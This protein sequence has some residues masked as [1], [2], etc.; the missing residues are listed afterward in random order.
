MKKKIVFVAKHNRSFVNQD[1]DILSRHYDVTRDVTKDTIRDCDAV[2]CWFASLHAINPLK[3]AK[4]YNK[5]FI[6]VAGGYDVAY[7]P[8][9]HPYGLATSPFFRGVPKRI[10]KDA[11]RILA[12]SKYTLGEVQRLTDN[13]NVLYVPNG[14]PL[15][16]HTLFDEYKEDIAITVGFIDKVSYWRK[17]LDRF[18]STARLSP[19][20]QFYHIGKIEEK[21]L[22]R[23]DMPGNLHFL[24][25]VDDLDEWYRKA[26]V[27]CQLSRYESFGMSVI[28]AMNFGAVPLV[29]NSA[30]LP[31]VVG[32]YGVVVEHPGDLPLELGKAMKTPVKPGVRLW[33]RQYDIDVRERRIVEIV[34]GVL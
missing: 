11:A 12:V 20:Y 27:Y 10:L 26:R 19:E 33:L 18:I 32:D 25:Y 31:E 34:D 21:V 17:G 1:H 22:P 5:P 3:W 23:K 8:G 7:S 24:G 6:V 9:K 28:E 15:N 14:I 4:R 30:A 29:M 16:T 2:Y 13:P